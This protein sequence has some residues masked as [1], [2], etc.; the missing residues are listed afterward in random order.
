[1]GLAE[2][3]FGGIEP[4]ANERSGQEIDSGGGNKWERTKGD[5]R[6][7]MGKGNSEHSKM[8]ENGKWGLTSKEKDGHSHCQSAFPKALAWH[9][10]WISIS[11][12]ENVGICHH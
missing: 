11:R 5:G 3:R 7:G 1:M 6:E 9:V 2:I 10:G 12:K 8:E 4:M